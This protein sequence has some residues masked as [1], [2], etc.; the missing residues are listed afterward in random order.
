M[1]RIVFAALAVLAA[2][3]AFWLREQ[4][5]TSSFAPYSDSQLDQLQA[6][7]RG[8]MGAPPA[9]G[10]SGVSGQDAALDAELSLQLL[11]KERQR[12]NA[13][14]GLAMV[15]LLAVVGALVPG[16]R[17]ARGDRGEESRLRKAMGD[18]AV[19]LEGERHK[20][21]RLLGVTPEAPPAVI[22]AALVARL[23]AHDLGRLDGIAPE[24]RRMVLDQR[25]E[26]QRARDLLVRASAGDPTGAAPQQ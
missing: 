3:G 25:Q 20:A 1:R 8:V 26:L 14:R 22:D 12:R 21:A 13:L 2:G 24:L 15:S 16:H 19:L 4:S 23:A 6:G 18:P 11:Q 9:Q 5:S 10:N 7:Y 17:G